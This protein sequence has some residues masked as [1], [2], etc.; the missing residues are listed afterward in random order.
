MTTFEASPEACQ[1]IRRYR[2]HV[3]QPELTQVIAARAKRAGGRRIAAS[4][5][6]QALDVED[7]VALEV[8]RAQTGKPWAEEGLIEYALR[9]DRLHPSS[10]SYWRARHRDDPAGT[11]RVVRQLHPTPSVR[12]AAAALDRADTTFRTDED[13]IDAA[14]NY[15][16]SPSYRPG[17]AA[18]SDTRSVSAAGWSPM[19]EASPDRTVYPTYV[20][21]LRATHPELVRAA[22][23]GG[24]PPSM[25]AG[26]DYPTTTASGIDPAALA[27][28]PWRARLAAAWEPSL[29]EAHRIVEIYSDSEFGAWMSSESLARR[30]AVQDHVSDVNSW[31]ATSGLDT[32]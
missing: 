16:G 18:L 12:I 10:E 13:E 11:E 3:G 2:L 9:T 25:F 7:V 29:V 26:G 22:E 15:P 4:F 19:V 30:S 6:D 14:F 17:A 31:A 27:G 32:Q 24:P 28:L 23:S 20:D 21:E 1:L 8:R 5:A